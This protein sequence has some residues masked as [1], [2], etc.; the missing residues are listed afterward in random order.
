MPLLSRIKHAFSSLLAPDADPHAVPEPASNEPSA[1]LLDR[2]QDAEVTLAAARRRLQAQLRR[3]RTQ[4]DPLEAAARQ[5]L[6]E[7]REPEARA[8]LARRRAIQRVVQHVE[9]QLADLADQQHR[10]R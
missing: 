8:L 5:A 2:L 9:G 7:G 6:G 3:Q 10:L 1:A 4:F